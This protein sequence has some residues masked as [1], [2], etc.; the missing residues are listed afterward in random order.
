MLFRFFTTA[1]VLAFSVNGF[2]KSPAI[3]KA[4][5][6]GPRYIQVQAAGKPDASEVS[7]W[8]I[9]PPAQIDSFAVH[10][11]K[12]EL[13]TAQ[14]LQLNEHYYLKFPDGT[15]RFL[16]PDGI[17]DSLYSD[18]ALG[19]HK[20]GKNLNFRVFAP[21][22]KWVR[23]VVFD[24]YDSPAEEELQMQ[25]DKNGVWEY[26]SSNAWY[27]KYYGY[28][29]WGPPGEGEMFDS[30]V[31]VADPY[32]PA[33]VTL[34]HYTHPAKTLILP[35]V[36][37]DW[38]GDQWKAIAPRDLIIYEMHV[39]DMTADPSSGL[40][41]GE[42]GYY[43]SLIRP[44]Q[45]GG[46]PYIKSLGVNAVEL[47][48]AQDFANIEVPYRDAEAPVFNTWNPYA[49]NHWGYMTSYFFAPESYYASGADMLPGHYCGA[50][51][52]Q[53]KEFR[54]MVKAF[55]K[56]SMAV[57]MDV[58]YNHV[59]QYDYNPLKYIDKFYY[60]RLNNDGSFTSQS[61]CGN[62][63]KT[64]RPMSRRLIVDS[65][66]HWM[67]DY[68]VDG[69]RFDLASLIDWKTCD[70]ILREARKIN[71]GA[72]IIAEPWGGQYNPSG[73]SDHGWAAWNDQIRNGVKGQNPRDGLGF[74]FG[75]WQ[76]DNTVRSLQRYILGSLRI[77]GGQYTDVAHSVN[78]LASHD[79]YALGDFIRI[80]LGDVKENQRIA[81]PAEN[82]KLTPRQL[83]LNKLAALFLLTSQGPAMLTEGQ[84]YARSK[85]IAKT[86]SPDSNW[87]KIDHNSYNKDNQTNW[88][89]FNY[90]DM[91]RELV[92]YYRGLIRLRKNHPAF[93]RAQPN[94]IHFRRE[95]DPL[96]I[97]YRLNY[98]GRSYFVLLNGNPQKTQRFS[99]QDK[100]WAVLVDG[101]QAS[102]KPLRPLADAQVEI[103]PSSGMVFIRTP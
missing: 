95:Q 98:Q 21:R 83:K 91:N 16:I 47:L 67:K 65:V 57:L 53:V 44:D 56:D 4:A 54:D 84:E 100:N 97:S 38:N 86:D 96:F 33:V 26:R 6:S 62:D 48:P 52:S 102:E 75:K 17:L 12:I 88:L 64:E 46:L 10:G 19:Y 99:F 63:L 5:I 27:G 41:D 23:L 24:H 45:R 11:N 49:R 37:Y 40:P 14:N 18:K 43:S 50:D 42:R 3:Q 70:T 103:P 13:F 79:D 87:Y 101:E 92:D 94:Q 66:I 15:R 20:E 25:R 78:Y 35:P 76:G 60:F 7:R 8:T 22:A 39:R 58:V 82:A 69:F 77:Y 36:N 74:I 80:G 31:V 68:H 73:F 1:L 2:S 81:D 29:V 89:N 32:S 93:R 51:G 28:R 9:T 61:G 59:S 85:V 90:S 55:H 71:P 72:V 30:T 34:N